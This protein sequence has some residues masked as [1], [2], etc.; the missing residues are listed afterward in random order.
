[1]SA[2]VCHKKKKREMWKESVRALLRLWRHTVGLFTGRCNKEQIDFSN[3]HECVMQRQNN[4]TSGWLG[5]CV[6]DLHPT[7]RT[8]LRSAQVSPTSTS[9][10]CLAEWILPLPISLSIFSFPTITALWGC[11]NPT[12]N[13]STQGPI[14]P[15]NTLQSAHYAKPCTGNAGLYGALHWNKKRGVAHFIFCCGLLIDDHQCLN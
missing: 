3:V 13:T 15:S 6:S 14:S 10:L 11:S 5:V 12:S 2:A 1:M 4:T 8:W 7:T 9:F